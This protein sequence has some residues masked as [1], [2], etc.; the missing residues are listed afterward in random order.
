MRATMAQSGEAS[1]AASLEQ[2]A[3][4]GAVAAAVFVPSR[5]GI[6]HSPRAF[7]A[8]ADLAVGA[9]LATGVL[10]KHLAAGGDRCAR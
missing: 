7:T 5:R 8:P 3:G 2:L 10:R 1:L 6:S 4:F 9:R